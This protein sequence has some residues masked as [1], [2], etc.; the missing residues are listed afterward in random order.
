MTSAVVKNNMDR[1]IGVGNVSIP[2][3]GEA[4]IDNWNRVKRSN[5]VSVWLDQKLIEVVSTDEPAAVPSLPGLPGLP[6]P[7][8]TGNDD[9]AEKERI[10]AELAK[11][12]IEKTKRSSLE[13][14]RK[15]LDAVKSRS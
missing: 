14:L 1:A 11:H 6:S 10:I 2:K 15:E 4:R 3:G 13:N 12:G 8:S 9:D 5:A 7:T